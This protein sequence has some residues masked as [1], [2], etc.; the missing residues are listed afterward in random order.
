MSEVQFIGGAAH[1]GRP[2]RRP[3]ALLQSRDL[4]A[5]LQPPRA[6]GGARSE[7]AA[8]RARE[9]PLDLP[10]EPR[11][12][13]HDPRLGPARAARGLGHRAQ[14]RRPLRPGAAAHDP[15]DRGAR[16]GARDADA[17]GGPAA[18]ARRGRR[19][20]PRV[21]GDR[22]R[23]PQGAVGLLRERGLPGP[24]AARVRPGASVSVR[25][26]PLALARRRAHGEE[27]EAR[28][29]SRASR[30]RPRSAVRAR[31]GRAGQDARVRPAR[32]ARRGEPRPPVS[33]D[34]D[35][36]RFGLPRHARRRHRDPRGRGRRPAR[37]RGRE[38][39]AAAL[40]RRDP[41]RGRGALPGDRARAPAR[42]SS[43]SSPTTSTRST[44]RSAP[45][46]CSRS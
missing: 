14:R 25:L 7:L 32:E 18:Q 13:L 44:A 41:P 37:Q 35:P 12:V 34:G 8:A 29:P 36:R 31:P 27:G 11:R 1:A 24:D 46:T 17:Q 30:C 5:R 40:R 9:V 39:P 2:A 28:R 45:R 10:L 42:R 15:R 19:A 23:A 43:S 33:R 16:R 21:G 6:R 20:D 3:L 26:E 38:R 4:L 22:A